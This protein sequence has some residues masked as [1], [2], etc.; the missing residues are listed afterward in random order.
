MEKIQGAIGREKDGSGI[1]EKG[2]TRGIIVRTI[3]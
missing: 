3:I 2:E 1:D